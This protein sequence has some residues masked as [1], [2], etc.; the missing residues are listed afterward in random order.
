MAYQVHGLTSLHEFMAEEFKHLLET[1]F[2]SVDMYGVFG[3]ELFMQYWRSNRK[4]VHTF[5]RI[6]IFNLSNRLPRQLKQHLFAAVSRLM[7]A[8]LKRNSPD[9][10]NDI[11]HRDFI[12]RL[13]DFSGC[14]DFFAV[15]RKTSA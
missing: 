14:L 5:M 12:F 3:N 6:D 11:T 1:H 15:C 13:D 4:W 2:G 8:S 9:L 7:R 10:C